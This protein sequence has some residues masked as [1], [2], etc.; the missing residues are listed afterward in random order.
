MNTETA[1]TIVRQAMGGG[2]EAVERQLVLIGKEGGDDALAL[3]TKELTPAEIFNI[4]AESDA[5]KS[6]VMQAFVSPSQLRETFSHFGSRYYGPSDS[7][8]RDLVDFLYPF[9]MEGTVERRME[10]LRGFVQHPLGIR[11]LCAMT[12]GAHGFSEFFKRRTEEIHDLS[13]GWQDIM[14]FLFETDKAAFAEVRER[15]MSFVSDDGKEDM[16]RTS[17]FCDRTC[18]AVIEEAKRVRKASVKKESLPD[19]VF[20]DI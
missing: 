20:E 7:F 10:M 17:K 2:R 1:I 13:A 11:A 5:T 14:K 6:S 9:F 3:V 4:A 16:N 8:P 19:E 12:L 15:V 18:L